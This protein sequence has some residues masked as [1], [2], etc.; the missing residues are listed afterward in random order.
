LP[1]DAFKKNAN[2]EVTT[3]IVML[4][5]RLPGELPS[6]PAWKEIAEITNFAG[7]T[8][9]VNEYFA[10]HPEMMLGEMR[11][12]GK[13][14]ARAEPTLVGNGVPLEESLAQAVARLPADVFRS[15]SAPVNNDPLAHTF[16]APEH[17]K[18][19]AYTLVNERIGIR[20]GDAVR[21]LEGLSTARAQRIRGMIRIRDAVR[22]CLRAQIEDAEED[23]IQATREQLNR[24]YDRFVATH[25]PISERTNVTAFK[26]DPDLPFLLSLEHYDPD[27]RRVT[28]AAI[29]RER[30][31]QPGRALPQV[32]TPQ[33]A[34]L[35]TLG[36]R[37]RVDLDLLSQLLHRKPSEFLPDLKGAI[38]LNPQTDLWETDDEYLSG[39]VRAK[40]A[41]AEAAALADKQFRPNV[42]ALRQVQPADLPAS[43]I[44]ARLGSVWIPAEDV[45]R[46]AGELLGEQGVS[47][48]HAPQ[49]GLW[50]VQGSY[51]VRASVANT[52]EWGTDRRSAL[53]LLED[54]LN[55][56]TPT[57]YDHDPDTDRE[58]INAPATEA[59]R[60][61]Q[62]KI[63]ERF[64]QWVWQ[65]DE[66][67]ERL[68]RRY[69]DEFNNVRLRA[70]S[71]DHL[72]LPGASSAITLHPHQRAGIWRILQTHNCLLAHVVGA[73]KT[74]P[75][76][77]PRWS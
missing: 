3:D 51:S 42:E 24:T 41:V 29:F 43:E 46:F 57:V 75:W 33:D 48:S 40:L 13:M 58:V 26:G 7:E 36:E 15:Q 50:T 67:R 49:L 59:A 12:E 56:R 2:T 55:L 66:R 34:L 6:G 8:I 76:L 30:T 21:L 54:A 16:P 73:G 37:G 32:S 39:N 60:D 44:D 52:T 53:E 62:D 1:N 28:K 11:L 27:T 20:E 38:Y 65:D 64:K 71:G 19:N 45:S 4:R 18:P 72:R 47:V 77:P 5:K 69:N 23:Q 17:V 35:V 68:A 61:K 9:P 74:T 14:Y 63:K 31:V 25:G 22:G 10:A 70:F